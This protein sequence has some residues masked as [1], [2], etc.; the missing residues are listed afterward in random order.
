M[1][2]F[3]FHGLFHLISIIG[4]NGNLCSLTA[5][6]YSKALAHFWLQLMPGGAGGLTPTW[7]S[8]VG[9]KGFEVIF[10]FRV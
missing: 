4:E 10:G 6:K 9:F 7:E 5:L 8:N 2:H 1:F 3:I